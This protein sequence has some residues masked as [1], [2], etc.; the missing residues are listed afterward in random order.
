MSSCLYDIV[1]TPYCKPKCRSFP[2][3]FWRL[4]IFMTNRCSLLCILHFFV[5]KLSSHSRVLHPTTYDR[6]VFRKI[7]FCWIVFT[8]FGVS[9]DRISTS[10][11]VSALSSY[12]GKI[13]VL[14]IIEMISCI[15]F[16]CKCVPEFL[17]YNRW[18]IFRWDSSTSSFLFVWILVNEKFAQITLWYFSLNVFPNAYLFH[19]YNIAF[20]CSWNNRPPCA[21]KT[22]KK[23]FIRSY[24]KWTFSRSILS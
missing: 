8:F 18:I 9:I 13:L 2:F 20:V 10:I 16:G 6:L 14:Q 15:L 12:A 7:K 3:I 1:I 23:P 24:W 22:E 5:Y 17:I 21:W 11:C 19:H 4:I